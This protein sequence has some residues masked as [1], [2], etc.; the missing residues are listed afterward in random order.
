MGLTGVPE[1][2]SAP[3]QAAQAPAKLASP[4]AKSGLAALAAAGF[5]AASWARTKAAGVANAAANN[6]ANS[7]MVNIGS[8]QVSET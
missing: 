8:V 7:F 2:P 1:L 4:L 6:K 5:G 3:W